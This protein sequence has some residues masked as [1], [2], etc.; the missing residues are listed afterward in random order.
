MIQVEHL[1]FYYDQQ[2]VLH[3]IHLSFER[4]TV[5]GLVGANGAGKSTLMR[6]IAGL[7]RPQNGQVLWRGVPIFSQLRD[8]FRHIGYLP[9]S[10]GLM[11]GLNVLQCL[12]YAARARGVSQSA[13][14]EVLER[15]LHLL[16]LTEKAYAD[17]RHLSRGQKQ[18][19]GIGQ[20]IIS[21]PEFL[22]LDEP[23]SGLDPEAR[24]HLSLLIKQ[25]QQEGMT[26][27]VSSHILSELDEYCT[28][29][30]A[31]NEGRVI[32]HQTLQAS[33][34][35]QWVHVEWVNE[36]SALGV[37]RNVPMI[38]EF[39]VLERGALMKIVAGDKARAELVNCLL[40]QG[41]MVSAI[42]EEKVSLLGSYQSSL[43]SIR[44]VQ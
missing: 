33:Q 2:Q 10:F 12:S 36:Q 13:L 39:K 25:L 41:V 1:D 43:Q 32:S 8:Y 20:I 42:Y 17:V 23:A 15:T 18:R 7:E 3:G 4:G 21:S 44:E 24:H 27:L 29:M 34:A 40:G 14:P 11:N 22:L 37:L 16:N 19:V 28:H 26:L 31:I 9:D 6:C 38:E 30:L 5:T 35:W